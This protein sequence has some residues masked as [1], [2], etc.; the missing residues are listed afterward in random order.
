LINK[1]ILKF[2]KFIIIKL[3]FLFLSSPYIYDTQY[4][5]KCPVILDPLNYHN[6]SK[7]SFR[8]D[9]VKECFL[10]AYEYLIQIKYK[11]DRK[12]SDNNRN[13]I[14]DLILNKNE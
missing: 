6:V 2:K 1:K 7:S 3:N 14:Y 12:D 11:Y 5:E 13:I 10:K 4:Y 9:E 8:I